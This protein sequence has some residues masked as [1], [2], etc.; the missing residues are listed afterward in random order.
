MFV[1]KAIMFIIYLANCSFPPE[2]ILDMRFHCIFCRR[3]AERD[4]P[5]YFVGMTL[6][7]VFYKLL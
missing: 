6:L 2:D 3:H 7:A 4:A 1:D 5:H